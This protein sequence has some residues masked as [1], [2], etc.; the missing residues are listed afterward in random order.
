MPYIYPPHISRPVS[1]QH[2]EPT[3]AQCPNTGEDVIVS[4][5]FGDGAEM[6]CEKCK[7]IHKVLRE[8][9]GTKLV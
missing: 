3:K 6:Y 2:G 5:C 9:D 4:P 1:Q 7:K 8:V